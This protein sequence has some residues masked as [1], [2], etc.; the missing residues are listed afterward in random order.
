MLEDVGKVGRIYRIDASTRNLVVGRVFQ[1][2][3]RRSYGDADPRDD[4]MA[5][6]RSTSGLPTR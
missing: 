3:D 1:L 2:T 6:R 4:A 5:L